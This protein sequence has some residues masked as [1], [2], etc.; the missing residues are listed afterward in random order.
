MV[1]QIV[2]C[3]VKWKTSSLP[4]TCHQ[5]SAETAELYYRVRLSNT[6]T[7]LLSHQPTLL[8]SLFLVQ[9]NGKRFDI[10]SSNA[11]STSEQ[12]DNRRMDHGE[13]QTKNQKVYTATR[14]ATLQGF[15]V[16]LTS[17][18]LLRWGIP[19]EWIQRRVTTVYTPFCCT[20]WS[21]FRYSPELSIQL[22]LAW[23]MSFFNNNIPVL[24]YFT[25]TNAYDKLGVLLIWLSALDFTGSLHLYRSLIVQDCWFGGILDFFTRT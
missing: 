6:V 17:S 23:N 19:T 20:K 5:L 2:Y 4:C 24:K 8:H 16:R 13:I 9:Y 14:P 3:G 1:L 22:W 10:V 7:K 15:R 11:I 12:T 25:L 18:V 21:P